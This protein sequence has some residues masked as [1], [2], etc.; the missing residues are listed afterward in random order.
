MAVVAI[1]LSEK[2]FTELYYGAVQNYW[3]QWTFPLQGKELQRIQVMQI[4]AY[5]DGELLAWHKRCNIAGAEALLVLSQDDRIPSLKQLSP[6]SGAGK[7]KF[8]GFETSFEAVQNTKPQGKGIEK[9]IYYG[10]LDRIHT[11]RV[12]RVKLL[13]RSPDQKFLSA[14]SAFKHGDKVKHDLLPQGYWF[15]YAEALRRWVDDPENITG[16]IEQEEGWSM[17]RR[18]P[19][20][21]LSVDDFDFQNPIKVEAGNSLYIPLKRFRYSGIVIRKALIDVTGLLPSGPPEHWIFDYSGSIFK[22]ARSI[23]SHSFENR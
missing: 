22:V 6:V 10:F 17:Y 19:D 3:F 11:K 13:I 18:W 16:N 7:E 20:K 12:K 1:M 8:L 23:L 4:A 2:A 14:F 9:P 21:K 15:M 5:N